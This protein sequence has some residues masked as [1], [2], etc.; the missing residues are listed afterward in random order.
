MPSCVSAFGSF[1]LHGAL[2]VLL[3]LLFCTFLPCGRVCV[4]MMLIYPSFS[5]KRASRRRVPPVVVFS[6]LTFVTWMGEGM[7]P[8]VST[9]CFHPSAFA[10]PAERRERAFLVLRRCPLGGRED[11]DRQACE[12]RRLSYRVVASQKH[13]VL[14]ICCLSR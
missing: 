9:L 7:P 6:G 14:V 4:M 13:G 2:E 1:F 3:Y 12:S 11:P 5:Q 10:V 8:W